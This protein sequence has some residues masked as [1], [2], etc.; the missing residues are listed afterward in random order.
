MRIK[1]CMLMLAVVGGPV[2]AEE[3]IPLGLNCHYWNTALASDT[4]AVAKV[5]FVRGVYEGATAFHMDIFDAVEGDSRPEAS[6]HFQ[7]QAAE[8]FEQ[9]Y[10]RN[11]GYLRLVDGLDR[12]CKEPGNEP[13]W[14]TGAMKVV[15]MRLRGAADAV[16]ETE[17][18]RLRAQPG[19]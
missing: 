8:L 15:S 16:I 13:V 17:M 14:L 10:Y 1:W 11:T 4:S 3:M 9:R 18:Q 7:Q 5:L 2:A 12:F 19:P 6:V